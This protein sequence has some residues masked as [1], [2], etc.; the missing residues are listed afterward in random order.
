MAIYKNG[1]F[2]HE[3]N[4]GG[5]IEPG[6][7]SAPLRIGTKDLASFFHGAIGPI[8]IR[9][10]ALSAAEIRSLYESGAA[11]P[12]GLVAQYAGAEANGAVLH[13]AKGGHDGPIHDATWG[14]GGGSIASG[15]VQS[16]G[17]C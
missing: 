17:G 11:P 9:S 6:P 5:I 3:D 10:R 13:D 4:Y 2:R 16:G 12:N 1:A 15:S 7:G 8:Y 14:Q